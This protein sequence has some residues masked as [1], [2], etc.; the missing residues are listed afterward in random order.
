MR[1]LVDRLDTLSEGEV[2]SGELLDGRS[3]EFDLEAEFTVRCE[4]GTCFTILGWMA[5][6]EVLKEPTE[7]V[8]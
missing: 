2:I 8:M 4:D 6:V 5:D 3:G 1:V 7:W